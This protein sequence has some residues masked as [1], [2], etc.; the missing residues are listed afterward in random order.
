M[1]LKWSCL[2]PWAF[3]VLGGIALGPPMGLIARN[4]SALSEG[5]AVSTAE[6]VIGVT[7]FGLIICVG[8]WLGARPF[9]TR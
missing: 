4:L 9:E 5:R 7:L 2:A 1:K 6:M 3:A 8:R